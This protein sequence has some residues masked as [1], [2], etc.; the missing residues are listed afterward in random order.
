M[1]RTYVV[2]SRCES[3]FFIKCG[4]RIP[5]HTFRGNP[6]VGEIPN[7]KIDVARI[8]NLIEVAEV[9]GS[10]VVTLQLDEVRALFAKWSAP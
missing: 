9:T 5:P 6:C 7:A 8:R 10:R 4:E 2:C 1:A 3:S